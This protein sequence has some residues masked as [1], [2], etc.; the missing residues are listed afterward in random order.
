MPTD[1]DDMVERACAVAMEEGFASPGNRII[2]TAG[3]PFGTPGATNMLRI[4][5]VREDHVTRLRIG[6]FVAAARAQ[7]CDPY[8]SRPIQLRVGLV[9]HV[10]PT[11]DHRLGRARGYRAPRPSEWIMWPHH[12]VVRRR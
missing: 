3:V 8:R 4:A 6:S 11:L 1:I 7:I 5:F 12:A 10:T 9:G 2:V